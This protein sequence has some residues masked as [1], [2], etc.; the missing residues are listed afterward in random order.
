MLDVGDLE[1]LRDE[2]AERVEE[3]RRALR[4]R[5]DVEQAEPRAASRRWS[6]IPPSH[7]WERVSNDDIGEPGCKYWHSTPRL[8]LRRD[9]DGLVAREDLLRMPIAVPT[10]RVRWRR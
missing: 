7:K 3:I 5:A 9:A 1:A 2:L 6:P 4:E 8:G 10:T